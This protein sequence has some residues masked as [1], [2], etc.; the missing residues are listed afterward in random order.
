[1]DITLEKPFSNDEFNTETIFDNPGA[2]YD[3]YTHQMRSLRDAYFDSNPTA[4]KKAYYIFVIPRFV[5]E[6]LHGFMAQNKA[7]GF[8]KYSSD[9]TFFLHTAKNLARGIGIL[10]NTW[11][12]NGPEQG[13]TNNLMDIGGGTHLTHFQWEQLKHSS[14]SYSY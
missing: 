7:L 5:N 14:K 13:S 11:I 8:I 6:D 10:Q 9:S 2:N 1:F 4:N 3:H 12:D